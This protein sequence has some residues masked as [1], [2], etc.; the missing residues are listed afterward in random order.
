MESHGE[1]HENALLVDDVSRRLAGCKNSGETR[2]RY[3]AQTA[4][5][6]LYRPGIDGIC[7]LDV[8]AVVLCISP[9]GTALRAGS[10]CL[11]LW[12]ALVATP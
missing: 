1:W 12:C 5:D 7:N 4:V 6:T 2:L 9:E 8:V 3:W 11:R 10:S